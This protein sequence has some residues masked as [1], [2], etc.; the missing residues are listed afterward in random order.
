MRESHLLPCRALAP[1]P[2]QRCLATPVWSR[3]SA[4]AAHPRPKTRLHPITRLVAVPPCETVSEE[5]ATPGCPQRFHVSGDLGSSSLGITLVDPSGLPF[6]GLSARSPSFQ[7]RLGKLLGKTAAEPT[8]RD[9]WQR[10]VHACSENTFAYLENI[11]NQKSLF[12][13]AKPVDSETCLWKVAEKADEISGPVRAGQTT[14]LDIADS[15]LDI[16]IDSDVLGE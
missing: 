3:H 13:C 6:A 10:D 12:C 15:A 8:L 14:I 2:L 4:A 1:A 16:C 5:A 11:H 7:I 9:H